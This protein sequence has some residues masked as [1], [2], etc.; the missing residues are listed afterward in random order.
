M[1]ATASGNNDATMEL[2]YPNCPTDYKMVAMV[3]P[4]HF[5]QKSFIQTKQGHTH[6]TNSVDGTSSHS[7]T[8]YGA[9]YDSDAK[10]SGASG[11]AGDQFVSDVEGCAFFAQINN[12]DSTG[13]VKSLNDPSKKFIVTL[14]YRKTDQGSNHPTPCPVN[15]GKTETM[16]ATVQTY[17]VWSPSLYDGKKASCLAAGYFYNISTDKCGVTQEYGKGT[18]VRNDG[19]AE[20]GVSVK[21]SEVSKETCE[22]AGFKWVAWSGLTPDIPAHCQYIYINPTE[23]NSLSGIYKRDENGNVLGSESSADLLRRKA[24]VCKAAGYKWD[25]ATCSE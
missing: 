23:V 13:P 12:K 16:H 8:V 9:T 3:I 17:C 25:G 11:A 14:G 24:A 15:N 20:F 5:G 19:N 10:K 7:H 1:S 21:S 4:T 6:T 18:S 22:A 2:P